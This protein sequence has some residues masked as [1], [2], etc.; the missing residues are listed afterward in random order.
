MAYRATSGTLRIINESVGKHQ[1]N[2]PD[3][4]A[5]VQELLRAAGENIG[6]D[7]QW[8]E[9]SQ[10]A[11]IAFQKRRLTTA[12]LGTFPNGRVQ[13][14]LSVG[15]P[16]LSLL[17]YEAGVLLPVVGEKGIEG[18]QR[19]HDWLVA[20]K[21]Q[22]QAGAEK[23]NGNRAV[24]GLFGNSRLAIQTTGPERCFRGPIL[25]DCTTYTNM[26]MAIYHEGHLHGSYKAA[27]D[28]TG[29]GSTKTE[30]LGKSRWGYE[31]L[32]C[33]SNPKPRNYHRTTEEILA[34]TTSRQDKLFQLEVGSTLKGIP[35]FVR[36]MALMY[37]QTVYECTPKP[38]LHGSACISRP[39]SEF[40]KN[41]TASI[42]YL[43]AEK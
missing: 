13:D 3:D 10:A 38:L 33:P 42:I 35:G 26:M 22:Y 30:H 4:V 5:S 34:A 25:L 6:V 12:P 32:S 43:F 24:W 8:G 27:L 7:R 14:A 18:F 19:M 37:G 36:H 28:E 1:R 9:K 31:L 20:N 21:V 41:K 23:G 29:G 39:L 40:M 17:A 2:A 16:V 15:S 11:L